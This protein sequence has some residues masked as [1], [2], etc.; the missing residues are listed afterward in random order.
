M[1]NFCRFRQNFILLQKI[2]HLKLNLMRNLTFKSW[3]LL[4][5]L[6]FCA[7]HAWSQNELIS[8]KLNLVKHPIPRSV[9]MLLRSKTSI[10]R[11]MAL[12]PLPSTGLERPVQC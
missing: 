8:Y 12:L 4:L 11:F 7:T 9:G 5:M 1:S 6:L 2:H 10:V 3:V